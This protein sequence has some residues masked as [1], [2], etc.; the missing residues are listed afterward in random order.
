M[1]LGKEERES[2]AES[3]GSAM[4]AEADYGSRVQK[5]ELQAK[6]AGQWKTFFTGKTLEPELRVKFDPVTG[7]IR[8]VL[9]YKSRHPRL[10]QQIGL[11]MQ[12]TLEQLAE[13]TG[14]MMISRTN[15]VRAGITDFALGMPDMHEGYGFPVGGVRLPLVEPTEAQGAELRKLGADVLR[16]DYEYYDWTSQ[17]GRLHFLKTG[18]PGDA[19]SLLRSLETTPDVPEDIRKAAGRLISR[20]NPDFTPA[21]PEDPIEDARLIIGFCM[22]TGESPR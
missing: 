22:R 8:A 19:V 3:V 14:G 10:A 7:A 17:G 20:V 13:S 5:F 16:T 15:D 1:S 21:H 11:R 12:K 9:D 6:N 2:A 4:I 18:T